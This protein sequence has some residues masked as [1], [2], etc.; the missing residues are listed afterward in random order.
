MEPGIMKQKPIDSQKGIFADGMWEKIF[1][2]GAMIGILTLVAFSLGNYLYGLEVGRTMAFLSLGL[3]EL[4]HSFNIR[5]EESIFKIGIFHN[6]YL[7]GAFLLGALLQ[8]GVAI[9]PQIAMIFDCIPLN[10]T[11]WIYTILISI[12]PIIIVEIQKKLNE[13]KFGK[14]VYENEYK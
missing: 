12:S 10:I 6:R 3:L 13:V 5:S 11:Q 14:V 8:I 9:I 1:T 7:V 2:E 4:V